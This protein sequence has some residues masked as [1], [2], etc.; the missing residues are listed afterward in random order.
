M[1]KEWWKERV[2]YQIYPR[3]FQDSNGDGIGDLRGIINRLDYLSRLGIGAVWLCPVYDSPNADMGYDIRDYEKIMDEFG[4]MEDFDE[5]LREMHERD[6]KLVMDLVVNHSSDEHR[7][8]TES[9][10]SR[11]NPYRD[12]YIWRD[13]R[14]SD[15]VRQ[16]EAG[17]EPNNWCSFFTPSAWNYD[18]T[19]E[20]WYLHLFAEKQPDLNWE[21]EQLR[22]EIYGMINRWF[23]KGVDGFRM[24]VISL[25][26]KD[27][28]LPDMDGDGYQFAGR[29]FAFQPKLHEYLREMREKCFD[30]RN[31]M[32]VGET[33]CVN[34][35][36][37]NTV[38][39]DGR[40]LDMLFQFDLMDID[41]DGSKWNLKPFSPAAF[42]E[43]VDKW[44]QAIEWNTLFLGNHDQPRAVSRFG[45]ISTDEMRVRSAKCLATAM[46]LLKGTPFIYQGEELGMTNYPFKD[47]SELRDIESINLLKQADT[48]ERYDHAW[49]GILAKG[50]DNARTPMQ[51]DDSVN[52]G[53]TA[54]EPWIAVNPVYTS[55]NALSEI[56]DD[57][58][59]FNF[60]RKLIALRNG[61]DVLKFGN[62]RM[63]DSG[64]DNI[65][66]YE[67]SLGGNTVTILCNMGNEP[68]RISQMPA[69]S[70][71]LRNC[72]FDDVIPPY[73]AAVYMNESD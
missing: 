53:F 72:D 13:G 11:N 29:Y 70:A 32:C 59:V 17:S 44:Q 14:L 33:T 19:T 46:Y 47:E 41:G 12:Y 73:G 7:W 36:N 3:S 9:K 51:W 28:K 56:D 43:V 10:K 54:G 27:S 24:D 61:S 45:N 49:S 39:G 66:E 23:D 50:R 25:I 60:Y 4:S 18:D 69:G 26:A 6:I 22:N 35:D 31:C 8:F 37:A 55:V 20:Q 2:F 48:K 68:L 15:N 21:N 71:V 34:T 65:F 62:Y 38:V 63:L 30:G 58:S 1:S 16:G 42:K 40:E 52:A 57:N 64:Y 67:R 5:L